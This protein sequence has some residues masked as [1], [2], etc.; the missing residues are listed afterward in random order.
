MPT[1]RQK[2]A[3][4]A[5]AAKAAPKSATKRKSA[6][7]A[8]PKPKGRPKK[9]KKEES[10]DED[11]DLVDE[12]DE[13]DDDE[14]EDDEFDDEDDEDEDGGSPAKGKKAGKKGGRNG[15]GGD[16]ASKPGRRPGN[17]AKSFPD[18]DGKF[19]LYLFKNDLVKD[20]R[21]DTKMCMWRRDGSSLLQKYIRVQDED[22]DQTDVFFTASSVVSV[23]SDDCASL[24]FLFGRPSIHL[25]VRVSDCPVRQYS[26]WEEKRKN[27]FFQINVQCVGEKRDG[28]V[29]VV[30][31]PELARF[32]AEERTT[33]DNADSDTKAFMDGT[34]QEAIAADSEN[35][36][37]GAEQELYDEEEDE[38]VEDEE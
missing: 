36:P 30:D 29:K 10:E 21:T 33:A 11:E 38:E 27:D 25:R 5:V 35:A 12:E 24:I 13:D 16:A 7:A 14:E 20:F 8:A 31:V 15:G 28:K 4:G 9:V 34:E 26:C 19:E 32:A 23:W 18:K 37:A 3:K 1:D 22:A 2:G 6:A 17:H